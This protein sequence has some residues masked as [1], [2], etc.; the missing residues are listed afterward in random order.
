MTSA[1]ARASASRSRSAAV[2]VSTTVT[3]DRCGHCEVRSEERDVGAAPSRLLGESNAH[4]ARRAVA[5]DSA[6]RRAAR[7]S[8]RPRRARA[9]RS[10]D[11]RCRR[12]RSCLDPRVRSPRARPCDRRPPR[13]PRAR[14]RRAD[15]SRRRARGASRRSPASRGAAHMPLFIAGATS[16][17]PVVRERGLGQHVV[18]KAVREACQRVRRQR[19]DNEEVPAPEVRVRDR[20]SARCARAR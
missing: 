7:A 6:P 5:D 19:R 4:A 11:R 20:R 15:E 14:P 17:G 18:G 1:S 12:R 13:P 2:G 16:T 8:H 3:P 9:S 10:S